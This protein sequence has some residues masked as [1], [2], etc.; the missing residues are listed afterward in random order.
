M[1]RCHVIWR[2]WYCNLSYL[3]RITVIPQENI[4]EVICHE[5]NDISESRVD[6]TVNMQLIQMV[7]GNVV[8][9]TRCSAKM[10]LLQS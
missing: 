2:S 4:L 7:L 9:A 3:S 8:V 1:I 10:T 6:Y 5:E